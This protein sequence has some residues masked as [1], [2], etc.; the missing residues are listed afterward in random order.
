MINLGL[1]RD[2][3]IPS[4]ADLLCEVELVEIELG[5]E[6]SDLSKDERMEMA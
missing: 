6:P 5:H 2:P 1:S 4:E 3:D